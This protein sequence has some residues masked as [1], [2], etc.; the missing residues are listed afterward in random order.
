M[1]DAS[2]DERIKS[3]AE[4]IRGAARRMRLMGNEMKITGTTTTGEE[5]DWASYRGKTVLVDF[6]ASWCG[7]CRRKFLT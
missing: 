2:N 3:R 4:N 1:I 5:F 6:W 7:P